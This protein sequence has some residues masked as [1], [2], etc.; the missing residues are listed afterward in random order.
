[1]KVLIDMNLSRDWISH[2]ATVGIESVH[3]SAI[4]PAMSPDFEIMAYA[5]DKGWVVFTHDLDF[6]IL[7]ASTRRHKP[8]A[9][10]LQ[11]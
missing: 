9:F 2:L 8:R 1:M 3:W 10:L 11:V 7:L 4:G 5:R 6:G